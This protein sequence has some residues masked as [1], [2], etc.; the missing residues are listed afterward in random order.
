MSDP[1]TIAASG[2]AA[3]GTR[4]AVSASNIANANTS[5]AVPDAEHPNST[6]YKPLSVSQTALFLAQGQPGGVS[7]RVQPVED[8]WSVSF[9]PSDPHA[10]KDGFIAVPNVDLAR[11]TVDI[12]ETKSLFRANVAVV[13]TQRDMD[14]DLLDI[15]T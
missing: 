10:N 15:L 9:Q 2:L 14:K 13:R 7:A 6:V 1:L 8:G 11:Q 5:G 3:L 12:I 4:L